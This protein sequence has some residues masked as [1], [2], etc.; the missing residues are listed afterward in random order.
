MYCASEY[1]KPKLFPLPNSNLRPEEN[2]AHEDQ[3]FRMFEALIEENNLWPSFV[4]RGFTKRDMVF[5]KEL[6]H[7]PK[8]VDDEYPF[9]GR[10]PGENWIS[11]VFICLRTL[12]AIRNIKTIQHK[13]MWLHFHFLRWDNF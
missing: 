12:H 6:I 7:P 10:D 2:W 3:S 11:S 9:K 4:A 13:D 1:Q 8:A 5:I